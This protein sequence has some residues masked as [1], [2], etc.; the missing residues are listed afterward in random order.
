MFDINEAVKAAMEVSSDAAKRTE[1]TSFLR[2]AS[3]KDLPVCQWRTV[4]STSDIIEKFLTKCG[5]TD[6]D[7]T[8]EVSKLDASVRTFRWGNTGKYESLR[9]E[10]SRINTEFGDSDVFVTMAAGFYNGAEAPRF[11]GSL[12]DD[13][14]ES[15]SVPKQD[16]L[17]V[18]L[19]TKKRY[20]EYL[21]THD[22]LTPGD[23]AVPDLA[24]IERI[25]WEL[26][27]LRESDIHPV[28][29]VFVFDGKRKQIRTLIRHLDSAEV[30]N[31]SNG[32]ASDIPP[33]EY[34]YDHADNGNPNPLR[35]YLYREASVCENIESGAAS[36]VGLFGCEEVVN[37]VDAVAFMT[38]TMLVRNYVANLY[39]RFFNVKSTGLAPWS[40]TAVP[41]RLTAVPCRLTDFEMKARET[42]KK[43][44]ISGP[45]RVLYKF[46]AVMARTARPDNGYRPDYVDE[47][48]STGIVVSS[49]S[50]EEREQTYADRGVT[51]KDRAPEW[52]DTVHGKEGCDRGYWYCNAT[53]EKTA[54]AKVRTH[55]Y[56]RRSA[57]T[58][59]T[60]CSYD[61]N[62]N[63]QWDIGDGIGTN[64]VISAFLT[65]IGLE[66]RNSSPGGVVP[67]AFRKGCPSESIVSR[68]FTTITDGKPVNGIDDYVDWLAQNQLDTQYDDEHK[69]YR[70]VVETN[71]RVDNSTPGAFTVPV[72]RFTDIFASNMVYGK[73]TVMSPSNA[74]ED[75]PLFT[76]EYQVNERRFNMGITMPTWLGESSER[77]V[78][79][80]HT[81][82][83]IVMQSYQDSAG[84]MVL[85]FDVSGKAA[86]MMMT[87]FRLHSGLPPVDAEFI[88]RH[89]GQSSGVFTCA[90][91]RK[92][93]PEM[94]N[95]LIDK[96]RAS[97]FC[98]PEE[99][100][101]QSSSPYYGI[102][103]WFCG[104]SFKGLCPD[105][106]QF[107]RCGGSDSEQLQYAFT[108]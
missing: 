19:T 24:T 71:V 81:R 12:G 33:A 106:A 37:N 45:D 73:N 23:E 85:V 98:S 26:N 92:D 61:A 79:A 51:R 41:C 50:P 6:K 67:T 38:N 93:D 52:Y 21:K 28:R 66:I 72:S 88:G 82:S 100:W 65:G 63:L 77:C 32:F 9:G 84:R 2:R 15:R 46:F 7:F 30:I 94:V 31:Y 3:E 48:T 80:G 8:V 75:K 91:E 39:T 40:I 42:A 14:G 70:L 59:L 83:D 22:D 90:P 18:H 27:L 105:R 69:K 76:G 97:G 86:D 64:S 34:S 54:L 20:E 107:I 108:R 104:T 60:E 87:H 89:S 102:G 11:G 47:A 13:S 35:G 96:I 29:P 62:R 55:W 10:L 5:F 44:G 57:G 74:P 43:L 101:T 78:G 99:S 58:V 1:F 56:R 17:A 68:V 53:T 16:P 95:A 103:H 36:Y 25:C 49:G 4:G